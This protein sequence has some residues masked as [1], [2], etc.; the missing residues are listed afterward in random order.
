VTAPGATELALSVVVVPFAGRAA[1]E[2][3]LAA[4]EGQRGAPRFE[5]IVPA[6]DTV[7]DAPSLERRGRGVRVV[8]VAGRAGPAALRAAGLR[9]AR[10]RIVAFTEDHC[11]P[12]EDWCAAIARAHRAPHAA[13]GGVVEK[14]G[15]DSALAWALYLC[16]YGRYMRPL[17]A[18]PA[19]YLTDVNTSYKRAALEGLA[20][21]QAPE[22]HETAVNWALARRGE[23]LWLDPAI[24]VRQARRVR[25]LPALRERFVH[26]WIFA[27]TRV[28]GMS[29]P[30]RLVRAGLTPS[31]PGVMVARAAGNAVRRRRHL[32]ALALAA[33]AMLVATTAWSL[34][35]LAG[36]VLGRGPA[37]GA[38]T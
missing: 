27:G 16:D 24:V 33:P 34:G 17:P 18:G 32:G 20:E 25:W 3:C 5:V 36:Y 2:R 1:L 4:L 15:R 37:R 7:A 38:A 6:D 35:E 30:A 11:E 28:P 10:G 14:E 19:E 23:T 21:A 29:A 31:L 8:P 22:L 9:A 26:G 13:V 12:A